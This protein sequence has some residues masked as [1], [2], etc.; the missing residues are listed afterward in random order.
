[1]FERDDLDYDYLKEYLVEQHGFPEGID[2]SKITKENTP[3]LAF[4]HHGNATL[5]DDPDLHEQGLPSSY[6]AVVDTGGNIH[7][8]F[9]PTTVTPHFGQAQHAELT[10]APLTSTS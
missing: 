6:H 7:T 10:H 8:Q 5:I 4:S 3:W 9:D 2:L 1:M